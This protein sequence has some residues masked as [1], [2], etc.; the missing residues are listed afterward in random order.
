MCNTGMSSPLRDS[1]STSWRRDIRVWELKGQRELARWRATCPMA[2]CPSSQSV[3]PPS[4]SSRRV[5]DADSL[6]TVLKMVAF[7]LI[8]GNIMRL[9]SAWGWESVME[10]CAGGERVWALGPAALNSNPNHLFTSWVVWR[11]LP[12]ISGFLYSSLKWVHNHTQPWKA[13]YPLPKYPLP[14]SWKHTYAI[15]HGKRGFANVM[16]SKV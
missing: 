5:E 14:N 9:N 13:E 11:K 15:L 1:R 12:K 4:L 8:L 10:Q 2:L 3:L 7:T 16:K 6:E